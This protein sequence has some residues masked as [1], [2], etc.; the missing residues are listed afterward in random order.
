MYLKR[1]V[2][3]SFLEYNTCLGTEIVG[4]K[5]DEINIR[6]QM[7]WSCNG[8]FRNSYDLKEE[9]PDIQ[10]FDRSNAVAKLIGEIT[11]IHT[12]NCIRLLVL[13][14]GK[15]EVDYLT[16]AELYRNLEER[17][18]I[19]KQLESVTNE[20]FRMYIKK[21]RIFK[22]EKNKKVQPVYRYTCS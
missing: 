19:L 22:E 16:R 5:N 15:E 8:Y 10:D 2:F 12:Y 17:N 21:I 7:W 20:K 18:K 14:D 13:F 4:N 6:Q 9:N 11:V 3:S 1:S